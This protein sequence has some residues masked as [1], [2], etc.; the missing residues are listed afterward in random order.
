MVTLTREEKEV[1]KLS[2]KTE[3]EFSKMKEDIGDERLVQLAGQL[4]YEGR[5]PMPAADREPK[6]NWDRKFADHFITLSLTDRT[7]DGKSWKP[8]T[9]SVF[10]PASRL[11]AE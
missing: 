5:K 3:A 11:S 8:A 1:A 6:S 9:G 4:A 2:G 7:P 10:R